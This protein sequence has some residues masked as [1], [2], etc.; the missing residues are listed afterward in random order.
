V[1]LEYV[2]KKGRKLT[3][4]EAFRQMCW[5]FHGK[6][7]SQRKLKKMEAKEEARQK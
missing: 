1:K 7:P 4:K 2:D 3:M 5:R 6:L